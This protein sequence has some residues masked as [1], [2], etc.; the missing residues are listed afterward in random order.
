[1]TFAGLASRINHE[2]VDANKLELGGFR[3][4]ADQEFLS[5]QKLISI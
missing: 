2:W 4:K 3:G 1:M 5:N